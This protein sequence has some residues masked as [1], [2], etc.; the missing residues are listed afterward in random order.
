VDVSFFFKIFTN[1]IL[2]IIVNN[3]YYLKNDGSLYGF[4]T[5]I[6]PLNT[7]YGVFIKPILIYSDPKLKSF[8][9]GSCHIILSK[10]NG[11]ILTFGSFLFL[12]LFFCY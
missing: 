1:F 10:E 3:T 2:N 8:K 12:F 11:E 9:C 4:G 7:S 5:I 6:I